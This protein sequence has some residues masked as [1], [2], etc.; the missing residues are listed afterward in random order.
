[1]PNNYSPQMRREE[2]QLNKR[3]HSEKMLVNT[4][5]HKHTISHL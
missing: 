4:H 2:L 1:M 5:M 3:S